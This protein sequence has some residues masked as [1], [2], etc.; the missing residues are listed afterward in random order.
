MISC[1]ECDDTDKIQAGPSCQG[2]P[3]VDDTVVDAAVECEQ[4]PERGGLIMDPEHS[5]LSPAQHRYQELTKQCGLEFEEAMFALGRRFG[6]LRE[7]RGLSRQEQVKKVQELIGW[8][9]TQ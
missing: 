5:S 3:R 6:G 4:Y 2:G 9:L 1:T 7:Y 8:V